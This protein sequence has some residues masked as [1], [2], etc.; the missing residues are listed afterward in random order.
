MAIYVSKKNKVKRPNAHKKGKVHQRRSQAK[1]IHRKTVRARKV[2]QVPTRRRRAAKAEAPVLE[3]FRNLG[4]LV[5]DQSF[6][7]YITANVGNEAMDIVKLLSESPQTDEKLAEMLGLKI[8]DVRRMLNVMNGYSILRYDVNKD[9]RGWLIFKWRIDGEKLA[10]FVGGLGVVKDEAAF[11][12]SENCN[13][14]FVCKQCYPKEKEVLP[15]DTAFEAD[16]KC[17][18]GKKLDVLDRQ[19][20]QALFASAPA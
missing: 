17:A 9:G 19:G 14:Y 5:D 13:D 18:C 2:A 10:E 7:K 15:F 12:L 6:S 20:V 8:N 4:L 3:S 16:F 11:V 1:H